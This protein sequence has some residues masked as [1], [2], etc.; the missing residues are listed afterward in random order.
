M[1]RELPGRR[2]RLQDF[3]VGPMRLD[4]HSY[5]RPAQLSVELDYSGS[6]EFR[7]QAS[8]LIP[9]QPSSGVSVLYPLTQR[10]WTSVF[11]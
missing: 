1:E 10:T 4:L 6:V 2:R 3:A 11:P 9:E 7:Q 8:D 5:V